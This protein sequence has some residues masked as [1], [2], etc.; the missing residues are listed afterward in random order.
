MFGQMKGFKFCPLALAF[1]LIAMWLTLVFLSNKSIFG[2]NLGILLPI[3]SAA[4]VIVGK[5]RT[6]IMEEY[7]AIRQLPSVYWV[8]NFVRLEIIWLLVGAVTAFN[9]LVTKKKVFVYLVYL[10]IL[11]Y[12]AC[13]LLTNLV[14]LYLYKKGFLF[15]GLNEA[16]D[17]PKYFFFFNNLKW[18]MS[19]WVSL[20]TKGTF[21]LIVCYNLADV[22]YSFYNVLC[23][24]GSG[25]EYMRALELPGWQAYQE[26]LKRKK[27]YNRENSR[28]SSYEPLNSTEK[29]K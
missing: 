2:T 7:E 8:A 15:S 13:Y 18:P 19:F 4:Y 12:S 27:L 26:E 20:I 25:W 11:V 21:S 1:Y 10:C 23:A 16:K 17:A 24:K 14:L 22:V 6:G 3:H 9:Y 5:P 28:Y 29:T